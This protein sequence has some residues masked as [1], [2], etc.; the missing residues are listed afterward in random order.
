MALSDWQTSV[1]DLIRVADED[2]GDSD[3][4][5]SFIGIIVAISG[6]VLIALALNCQKLA[7]RRL[8]RE[9]R[10]HA[11]NGIGSQQSLGGRG[12]GFTDRRPRANTRMV[13]DIVE[14]NTDEE[15][16]DERTRVD[17]SSQHHSPNSDDESDYGVAVPFPTSGSGLETPSSARRGHSFRTGAHALQL[18]TEPLLGGASRT[19]TPN[20][21]MRGGYLREVGS[22][23]TSSE[24]DRGSW[25]ERAARTRSAPHLLTR[26]FS[27]GA[28]GKKKAN[29]ADPEALA[30][31]VEGGGHSTPSGA[32]SSSKVKFAEAEM[33]EE[34]EADYLKSKLW[35][36]GLILM[37]V[38][39]SGNFISY[40]FAPASIV[41]PLGTF[42]LIA[43]CFFAP[44][45][46]KE[47]FRKRDVLGILL[48]IAGA[49][50]V[51]LSA[52]SSDRRL[53]PEGLIEAITQQAFIILAAL[54]AGGIALLV[55]LSSRRIGRTHFWV[56]LGAC[57]L[58]GGFT[59]LSTKA[60]SSLLTKEWVA[61]FKEW[62]T[63]PVLAV[64][65]GTGIGQ[66]RYLNRA[67]MKFDSKVVIP[68]Q[69]VF[70]NISAIVGSAVLY[71][72]FRKATL[73]QMVTFLY[74][75]GAT[76]AG[77]FML[78]WGTAERKESARSEEEGQA[79]R[80]GLPQLVVQPNSPP[81]PTQ[82]V[83]AKTSSITLSPAQ[84]AL[85]VRTLSEEQEESDNS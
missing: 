62:I 26:I 80:T 77:V 65:I 8:E 34:N 81:R 17:G 67:L 13:S 84:R 11:L 32:C 61:I 85:L 20:G 49:I 3:N 24:A 71:G 72:D 46:L 35:W 69:F 53:S 7:H 57:A 18:E 78:T 38:G 48:A 66:I 63:Y 74:G 64:L 56:D 50:T 44:L 4:T 54:Y 36:L 27:S 29:C 58:F 70:F 15:D 28:K 9:R 14:V 33:H 23:G 82:L 1:Y 10:A 31:P 37:A 55:S 76:F 43:N 6:N 2:G 73:H 79:E 47:R 75:C 40:G 42:A 68:A 22:R 60:I 41:A 39:E 12:N 19:S 45:M 21:S 30:V 83:R 51:V 59:V 25:R 16:D 5:A 52:S